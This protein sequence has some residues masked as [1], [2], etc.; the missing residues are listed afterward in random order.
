MALTFLSFT[1][2]TNNMR[3]WEI[4]QIAANAIFLG[5]MKNANHEIQVENHGKH[6]KLTM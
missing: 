5:S 4:L 6:Q 2:H 1:N 3:A